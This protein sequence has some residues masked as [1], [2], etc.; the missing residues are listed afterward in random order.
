MAVKEADAN[1]LADDLDENVNLELEP[2][3]TTL[4][5]SVKMK[6]HNLKQ[7]DSVSVEWTDSWTWWSCDHSSM[8][9]HGNCTL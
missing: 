6:T 7:S 8:L 9:G 4:E 1:D 3:Q 2:K 5:H